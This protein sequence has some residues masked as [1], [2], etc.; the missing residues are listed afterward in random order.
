MNR[1]VGSILGL[2][3]FIVGC[4][5]PDSPRLRVSEPEDSLKNIV[6]S[7]ASFVIDLVTTVRNDGTIEPELRASLDNRAL[8]AGSS[9]GAALG[10]QLL[11][12][13]PELNPDF[14][15][16]MFIDDQFEQYVGSKPVSALTTYESLFG[17]SIV[18]GRIGIG[19]VFVDENL[20][21]PQSLH[22]LGV[23]LPPVSDRDL[24][25]CFDPDNPIGVSWNGSGQGFVVINFSRT[26]SSARSHQTGILED[27]EAL[28]NEGLVD[29]S[30]F[31]NLFTEEERDSEII[32]REIQQ[33]TVRSTGVLPQAILTNQTEVL[34][35]EIRIIEI[36]KR[37]VFWEK[38]CS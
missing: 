4:A 35:T 31:E 2:G 29:G 27:Q 32:S 18:L 12:S 14:D 20:V 15:L 6:D 9:N 21:M 11:L 23:S 13:Y 22:P 10:D 25:N 26:D 5:E 36:K 28:W 24:Y 37:Q 1:I 19:N 17:S 34:D 33:T 3:L 8:A 16:E 7:N 30:F 38:S